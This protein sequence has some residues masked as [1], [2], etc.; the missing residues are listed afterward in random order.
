VIT[1]D[2]DEKGRKIMSFQRQINELSE[3]YYV[4]KGQQS[5]WLK[6]N[7]KVEYQYGYLDRRSIPKQ[8]G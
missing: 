7:K 6:N 5:S 1:L 2:D 3:N 8:R 4:L